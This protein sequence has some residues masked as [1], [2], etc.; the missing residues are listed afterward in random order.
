MAARS[1]LVPSVPWPQQLRRDL[2]LIALPPTVQRQGLLV[3]PGYVRQSSL[4]LVLQTG[5]D[6]TS[7][8]L[9]DRVIFDAFAAEEVRVNDWPCVL[10]PETAIDAVVE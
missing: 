4:G 7:V 9:H 3:L 10:V 8:E 5:D 2:V 6:V 1:D